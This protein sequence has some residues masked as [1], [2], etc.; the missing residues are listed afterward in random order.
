MLKLSF[1][2]VILQQE[3]IPS[4]KLPRF[5]FRMRGITRREDIVAQSWKNVMF[6]FRR[7]ELI[8][9]VKHAVLHAYYCG[10]RCLRLR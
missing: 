1:A 5:W 2:D 10:L 6:A 9:S 4:A 3:T 8:E 7:D